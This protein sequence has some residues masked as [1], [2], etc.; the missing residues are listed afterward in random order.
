MS[1]Q[2]ESL[3]EPS[4]WLSADAFA[5][6]FIASE[7]RRLH[8]HPDQIP[9]DDIKQALAEKIFASPMFSIR[10]YFFTTT[11]TQ[12]VKTIEPNIGQVIFDLVCESQRKRGYAQRIIEIKPRQVGW[13]TWMIARGMW[14]G[15]QP[16]N[17]IVFMVSDDDVVKDINR[18][19]GTIYNNLGWITPMRRI[20]NQQRVHF[21]NPDPRTRDFEK[22]LES[23]IIVVPPGPIRGVTPN[24]LILSEF[25][26]WRDQANVDTSHV[27]TGVM[28]GMSAGPESAVVIDTTPNGFDED[29]Y[30]MAQE[31]MDRNPK[32]VR[33]WERKTIPT[34]Q[35]I[36]S[37]AFGEPDRPEAGWIPAFVSWL[38]HPEF[39]TKEDSPWGQL[40]KLTD[41]Q[42]QHIEATLG[43]EEKYGD[44]AE[45]ELVKKYGASLG[46]IHW[47]RWKI[48]TDIQGYDARQK[49]LTFT[50]EY[51]HNAQ[52][53]FVDFGNNAFDQAGLDCIRRQRK[54]PSARGMLRARVNGA[55]LEW[56]VD[57][58]W[59]S[60]WEEM[61]F[62]A[63]FEPGERYVIGADL[64]WSFDSMDADQ[65]YATVLRRRDRKQVAVYEARCPM[66]RV[67]KSL[68]SL[69]RYYGNA[70]LGI[71]VKGPGKNLVRELFDMGA[72][73]Q[74]R[75]KRLDADIVEDTKWLGWETSDHTRPIM[76]G[77]TVEAIARRNED[78]R[79]DPSIILRDAK[80]ILQLCEVKRYEDGK[81]KA[82]AG[83]HDDA[84]DA[85]MIALALDR[86][87]MN[88]YLPPVA[89]QQRAVS[90][91]IQT[92]QGIMAGRRPDRRSP[93]LKD[94]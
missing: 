12:E 60:D 81:I 61:R 38:W 15:I 18:R 46:R 83:R 89:V 59:Q 5:A 17:N 44:E 31:A 43:K 64:G 41:Q 21:S 92:Y 42:R 73:N 79:S 63:P 20:E 8:V 66:H 75:W 45:L 65:T 47:R 55:Y 29:Y 71:E 56:E 48:D 9:E 57:E 58:T 7:C 26:H 50:Q 67:R 32:W 76:E 30:P 74:Y 28:S 53:A 10:N 2:R 24:V 34:Q 3:Y 80:T 39:C 19:L 78:G 91:T 23:Q 4:D 37:G 82:R 51:L 22:G 33:A 13:T 1:A 36:V 14:R 93:S 88:P 94:M 62:W 52:D 16:N 87:P 11:K 86:D 27:L 40:K 84:A 90:S 85:L 72:T 25:A 70:F 69:Y 68:Y 6:D 77:V 35:E 54:N 49:V